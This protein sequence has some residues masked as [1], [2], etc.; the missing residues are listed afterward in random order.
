MKKID[1]NPKGMRRT[2]A[3]VWNRYL[4]DADIDG[5]VDHDTGTIH[6]NEPTQGVVLL[7]SAI[8]RIYV[9]PNKS[10]R[11]G[12]KEKKIDPTRISP[13]NLKKFLQSNDQNTL[14]TVAIMSRLRDA[15]EKD[16]D[17]FERSFFKNPMEAAK[18]IIDNK[19]TIHAHDV[20]QLAHYVYLSE[21]PAVLDYILKRRDLDSDA[22][23][24]VIIMKA[25]IK[26]DA[27]NWEY[28]QKTL[29]K[30]ND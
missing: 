30:K 29:W 26:K 24:I 8:K 25:G 2:S 3:A 10:E 28:L 12:V 9:I 11:G 27:D 18:F 1:V 13:E 5:F 23:E 17:A 7:A 16:N 4:R 15:L 19:P 22:Y 21:K 6:P 20:R 14:A